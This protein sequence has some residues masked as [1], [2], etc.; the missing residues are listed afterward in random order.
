M[1]ESLLG[2]SST[3]PAETIK[4]HGK[5]NGYAIEIAA[6]RGD[7]S[8]RATF[9]GFVRE[10]EEGGSRLIGDIASFPPVWFRRAF[11]GFMT[12][13][14]LGLVVAALNGENTLPGVALGAVIV[15]LFLRS[16]RRDLRSQQFQ[17]EAFAQ[18]LVPLLTEAI[19]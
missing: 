9:T 10:D 4:A 1:A 18:E 17:G 6:A 3:K 7:D 12:V 8:A 13:M 14:L 16:G 15:V 2:R 5:F 19:G 11:Y